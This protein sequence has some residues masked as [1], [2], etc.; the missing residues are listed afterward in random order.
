[1]PD[2]NEEPDYGSEQEAPAKTSAKGGAAAGH[3]HG[4]HTKGEFEVT[5]C[6]LDA[7]ETKNLFQDDL[8][9]LYTNSPIAVFY[10]YSWFFTNFLVFMTY[11]GSM[12]IM[13]ILGIIHFILA[14]LSYKFLFVWHN[15][16]AFGFDE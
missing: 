10:P 6:D 13:Y 16:I 2:A 14:Y 8:D 4:D 11:G 5:H 12:P 15:R 1:M 7:P 9:L 3:G